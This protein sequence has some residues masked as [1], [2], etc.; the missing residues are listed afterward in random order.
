MAPGQET[1]PYK[2]QLTIPSGATK[3]QSIQ[4]NQPVKRTTLPCLPAPQGPRQGCSLEAPCPLHDHSVSCEHLLLGAALQ[5][6]VHWPP[7]PATVLAGVSVARAS[8]PAPTHPSLFP[9]DAGQDESARVL[10]HEGPGADGQLSQ[11]RPRGAH[12]PAHP[13]VGPAQVILWGSFWPTSQDGQRGSTLRRWEGSE[14]PQ[15]LQVGTQ[16]GLA[17][18]TC[19]PLMGAQSLGW[20]QTDTTLGGQ[21]RRGRR[22]WELPGG[23]S[24]W[25]VQRR[26]GSTTT[27]PTVRGR[28]SRL[29][30]R[31][32]GSATHPSPPPQRRPQ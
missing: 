28:A 10:L 31:K 6:W 17:W 11:V 18:P 3:T 7:S 25:N 13:Q 20:G 30:R 16:E 9:G 29:G 32:R 26:T 2:A 24:W 14:G 23:R 8:A 21:P 19:H 5:P 1:R 12:V 22:D 4:I 27:G 15:P